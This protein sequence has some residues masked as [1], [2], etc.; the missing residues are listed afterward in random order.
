[1]VLFNHVSKVHAF[2]CLLQDFVHSLANLEASLLCTCTENGELV[3][4]AFARVRER[5]LSLAP[6]SYQAFLFLKFPNSFSCTTPLARH[7]HGGE[8]AS[9]AV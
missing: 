1:M 2:A 8:S 6:E 4:H 3:G 5:H 9:L 7:Y